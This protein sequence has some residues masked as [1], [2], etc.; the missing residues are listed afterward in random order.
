M[1]VLHKQPPPPLHI[2][3]LPITPRNR[4]SSTPVHF[5]ILT[6][7][8]PLPTLLKFIHP[9]PNPKTKLFL[10]LE[11][12]LD[13]RR[14][15]FRP[16][17]HHHRHTHT[18]TDTHAHARTHTHTHTHTHTC[19]HTHPGT[20]RYQKPGIDDAH[21][22]V[23]EKVHVSNIFFA[24]K[25]TQGSKTCTR[26]IS[27]SFRQENASP[28]NFE[29]G[30]VPAGFPRTRITLIHKFPT[31]SSYERSGAAGGWFQPPVTNSW[32]F[33]QANRVVVV[34]VAFIYS[35]LLNRHTSKK[36]YFKSTY[37]GGVAMSCGGRGERRKYKH[38]KSQYG[39]S[40]LTLTQ[41]IAKG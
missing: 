6:T 22:C 35:R 17:I 31:R 2:Y 10:K 20:K 41:R 12:Y 4:G 38:F 33:N 37:W 23:A 36:V 24:G 8:R 15:V 28:G 26:L 7:L 21:N 30:R 27:S 40:L 25:C 19:T 16:L 5:S 13:F 3:A 39:E 29:F 34:V 18:D 32:D 11:S 9:N 1:E 14:P